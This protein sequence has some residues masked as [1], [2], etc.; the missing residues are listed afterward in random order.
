MITNSNLSLTLTP[1]NPSN[2]D[3]TDAETGKVVYHVFTVFDPKT[4][5]IVEN[6]AGE[7]IASWEWSDVRSDVLTLGN[8]PPV[9]SSVW[10]KKSMV[11]FKDTVTFTGTD[12]KTYKWKGNSLGSSLELFS[13]DDKSSAI[14]RFTKSYRVKNQNTDP[15]T[16]TT[17]PSQLVIAGYVVS[18]NSSPD[19]EA[20]RL[21]DLIVVSFLMLEKS[22]R[23]RDK[24]V[25]NRSK[26]RVFTVF[27][28]KTTTVVKAA[29]ERIDSL[30]WNDVWSDVLYFGKCSSNVL[31]CLVVE[32][33]YSVI[34]R[35][36]DFICHPRSAQNE[37][38]T[39]RTVAFTGL[40][41]KT[42]K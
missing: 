32:E 12:T 33:D 40:D 27:N 30:E 15:P 24:S 31:E 39:I 16:Y 34:Q 36:G 6:A 41:N 7:K 3:L 19:H 25:T 10:L 13:P 14:A 35:V 38:R 42:Y 29:A 4:T 20:L 26:H 11:P 23:A 28:P 18:G 2:C 1:D 37:L 17:T 22:K 9:S 5:T 21:Q 8:A